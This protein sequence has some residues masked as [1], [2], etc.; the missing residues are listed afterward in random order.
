VDYISLGKII[1]TCGLHGEI[2]VFS[3]TEFG[4]VRYQ[5]NKSVQVFDEKEQKRTS[6]RVRLYRRN[7]KIDHISFHEINSVEEAEGLIGCYIQIEKKQCTLPDGF[8]HYDDLQKCQVVDEKGDLIGV[9]TAIEEYT[10]QKT[11][12]IKRNNG[13]DILVPFVDVFIKHINTNEKIIKI[14]VIEGLL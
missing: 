5:K 9:V 6:Y 2:K 12:R 11:L 8:F 10:T 7:G 14:H 4:D 13:P 1:G 3:T